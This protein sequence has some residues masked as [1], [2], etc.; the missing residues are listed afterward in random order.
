MLTLVKISM[1]IFLLIS[2]GTLLASCKNLP[3]IKNPPPAP[4]GFCAIAKIITIS[5]A[6]N[7]TDETA[8]EI[9]AHDLKVK[10]LCMG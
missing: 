6:D 5:K 7:L 2:L 9:L 8:R 4:S 10:Q 3:A 1:G